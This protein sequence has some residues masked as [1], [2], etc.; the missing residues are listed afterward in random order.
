[1]KLT[2][3]KNPELDDDYIDIKYRE[4]TPVIEQ[5]LHICRGE[6]SL[7]LCEKEGAAHNIDLHDILYI[8]WVDDRSF[9]YTKDEIFT[10]TPSLTSLEASLTDLHF[11]RIS[12]TCLCNLFK[13]KAVSTGL[14]MRLTAE[15]VN[16][17]R[18]V[19]SRHYR[20]GLLTAIHRLAM[21]VND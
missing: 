1:M 21:E 9:V 7:L 4:L 19:V 2:T 12:R 13:I 20:D 6:R 3:Q 10:M 5:I 17:E 14:N 18:V 11:I 16:G 15:M 8:E